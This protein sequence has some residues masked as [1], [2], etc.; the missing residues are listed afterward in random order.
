MSLNQVHTHVLS[1]LVGLYLPDQNLGPFEDL[2]SAKETLKEFAK[3][4]EDSC[5]D[6]GFFHQCYR[7]IGDKYIE[8]YDG[9]G[10]EKAE[11][12]YCYE[13]SCYEENC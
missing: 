4:V 3:S 5:D 8:F 11:I 1:G 10:V 13:E 7:E 6:E 2:K 12:D 9:H